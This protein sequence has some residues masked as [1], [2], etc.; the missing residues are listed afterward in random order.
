MKAA[1]K[2]AWGQGIQV[3]GLGLR[4]T[5]WRCNGVPTDLTPLLLSRQTAS[6]RFGGDCWS[7]NRSSARYWFC[8]GGVSSIGAPPG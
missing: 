1:G 6:P 4:G 2:G 7:R 5:F 8:S 3:Y